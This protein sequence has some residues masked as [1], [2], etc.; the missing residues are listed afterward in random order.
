MVMMCVNSKFYSRYAAHGTCN[1]QIEMIETPILD[2]HLGLDIH[3]KHVTISSLYGRSRASLFA[4]VGIEGMRTAVLHA[5]GAH[6]C[7][8][9]IHGEITIF[10]TCSEGIDSHTTIHHSL[11]NLKGSAMHARDS[12]LAYQQCKQ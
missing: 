3:T 10:D 7:V 9:V 12:R 2:L 8:L 4:Q 5:P 6:L 11:G 1:V